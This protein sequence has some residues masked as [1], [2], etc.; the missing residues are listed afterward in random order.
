MI[1]WRTGYVYLVA[2]LLDILRS[3]PPMALVMEETNNGTMRHFSML[4]T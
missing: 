3:S 1:Y 4:Y 2:I